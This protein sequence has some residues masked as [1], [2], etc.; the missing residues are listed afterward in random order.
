MD[1]N[2]ISDIML[3]VIKTRRSTRKYKDEPLPQELIDRIVEAGRYAPSGGN[4]QKT[5]FLIIRDKAVL[6][7]L[8]RL[9]TDALTRVEETPD[10][11]RSFKNSVKGAKSAAAEGKVLDFYYNA[12][13][14]ILTA[15][16][17]SY[18][19][20]FADCACA[21]EN[22]MLMA[23]A[24]DI[25][26]C[27]INTLRFVQEDPDIIT[28][29]QSLGM[30]D[31]ELVCGGVAIGYADTESGLPPKKALPRTGNKAEYL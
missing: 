11:Y 22:M 29:L 16:D 31:G 15:S 13:V 19:N 6:A 26:S 2:N 25:G 5:H 8:K 23:N 21:I 9:A 28:F 17:G 27:W 18:Y 4:N 24:M 7:K 3:S 1:C 12:P 14:L 10:M 20:R 30:E